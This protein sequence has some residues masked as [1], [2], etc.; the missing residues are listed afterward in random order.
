MAQQLLGLINSSPDL[1]GSDGLTGQ[2]LIT[3]A[4]NPVQQTE[5]NLLANSIGWTRR[6]FKSR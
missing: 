6:R 4:I 3:D 1:T 2:D 5:F